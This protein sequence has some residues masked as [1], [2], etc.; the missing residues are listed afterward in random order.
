M[1]HPL[2]VAGREQFAAQ[3]ELPLEFAEAPSQFSKD[4]FDLDPLRGRHGLYQGVESL[5]TATSKPRADKRKPDA[6]PSHERLRNER[7]QTGAELRKFEFNLVLQLA[8]VPK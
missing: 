7:T 5:S 4:D 6:F 8:H 2:G 3:K 1:E